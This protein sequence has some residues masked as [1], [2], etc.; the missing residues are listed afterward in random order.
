M[1]IPTIEELREL[2]KEERDE[3]YDRL[4]SADDVDF[5]AIRQQWYRSVIEEYKLEGHEIPEVFTEGVVIIEYISGDEEIRPVTEVVGHIQSQSE[6]VMTAYNPDRGV[7]CDL[8]MEE[9]RIEV[10]NEEGVVDSGDV[11][12][13]KYSGYP[14]DSITDP[15]DTSLSMMMSTLGLKW[16]EEGPYLYPSTEAVQTLMKR[17]LN[18]QT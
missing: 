7:T 5:V 2:D 14:T 1:G 15:M 13:L 10:R 9:Y 18:K 4:E 16:Q 12:Q 11:W 17:E 3:L 8:D 6:S